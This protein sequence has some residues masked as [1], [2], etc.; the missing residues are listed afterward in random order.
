MRGVAWILLAFFLLVGLVCAVIGIVL[1]PFLA[2]SE[3]SGVG[4]TIV[5][6]RP[7][8]AVVE[9]TD[10]LGAPLA[11]ARVEASLVPPRPKDGLAPL[12]DPRATPAAVETRTTDAAGDAEFPSLGLGTWTL[13]ASA[14]GRATRARIVEGGHAGRF[15]E[16]FRLGPARR[17]SGRVLDTEGR[18]VGDAVVL[19]DEPCSVAFGA[20][21]HRRAAC[22][23]DGRYEFPDLTDGPLRLAVARRDDVPYAWGDVSAAGLSALDLVVPARK[24]LRGTVEDA[25]TGRAVG[26]AKV[27][28]WMRGGVVVAESDEHGVWRAAYTPA[29]TA[30]DDEDMEVRVAA[31]GR[32]LLASGPSELAIRGTRDLRLKVAPAAAAHGRVRGPAG[33]LA[34]VRVVAWPPP[35]QAFESAVESKTDADG[36]FALAGV[37]PGKVSVFAQPDGIELEGA[38]RELDLRADDDA[39]CDFTLTQRDASP[40]VVRGRVESDDG[41]PVVGATIRLRSDGSSGPEDATWTSSGA[42]GAFEFPPLPS[43][44]RARLDVSAPRFRTSTTSW[45]TVGAL[46]SGTSIRLAHGVRID[47]RATSKDGRPLV[48]ARVA[49]AAVHDGASVVDPFAVL[50]SDDD[51]ATTDRDGRFNSWYS[52]DGG[53]FAV[54]VAADGLAPAASSPIVRAACG[55]ATRVDL[56][57]D[58]GV[59]IRG[60]A[61]DSKN[62]PLAGAVLGLMAE[63]RNSWPIVAM[64]VADASGRFEI[65]HLPPHEVQLALW[66]PGAPT[67]T[68]WATPSATNDVKFIVTR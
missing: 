52:G 64:A 3:P 25:T 49:A 16:A 60:V 20:V 46:A 62:R 32:H 67:T 39:V 9:V 45:S 36:R 1:L 10:E 12:F 63:A 29:D 40:A 24:E 53:T 30:H 41:A 68:R 38:S 48:G 58:V 42:D 28:V 23:P 17:L 35:T 37:P 54:A 43:A 56:V 55:A 15:T 4:A 26:G 51:P 33:P 66:N 27:T 47:G 13:V 6:P 14:P 2:T 19:A 34:G 18:A 31:P 7:A 5:D 61:L 44:A 8:R 65:P 50:W 21:A 59:P 11:G 22:G 57:L